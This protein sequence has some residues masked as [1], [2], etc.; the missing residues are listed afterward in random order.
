M[1][2]EIWFLTDSQ[3]SRELRDRTGT[4]GLATALSCP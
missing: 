2:K 4:H 1:G 3:D